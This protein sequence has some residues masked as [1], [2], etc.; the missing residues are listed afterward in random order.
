MRYPGATGHL[1][2]PHA[3]FDRK[4]RSAGPPGALRHR[5]AARLVT[6]LA[7]GA[8]VLLPHD[9]AATKRRAFVTS[10]T[11]NGNLASWPGATGSDALQR[12]DSICRNQA[13]AGLLPNAGTYRAWISTD[14]TDAYCHVQGLTGTRASGCNGAPLPGGGPWFL[15]NGI[16]NYTGTLD[17]IT[18]PDAVLYRPVSLDENSDPIPDRL[19]R[20]A[21]LDRYPRDGDA[22][23][24]NCSDW[25]SSASGDSGDGGDALGVGY[26]FSAAA[27]GLPVT[28]RT[29]CSA[30]NPARARP[31][32]S[33]GARGRSRS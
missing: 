32:P 16:S 23:S 15:A 7:A 33:A 1:A 20:A 10:V 30:W 18:G 26:R 6:L 28:P 19:P 2:C 25:T 9:A 22:S 3:H 12:A 17:Q 4:G 21:D 14:T 27:I 29:T 5:P 8:L 24:F 31:S 13:A 11:G